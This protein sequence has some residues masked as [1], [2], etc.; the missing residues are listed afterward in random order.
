M[1]KRFIST[2]TAK[3]YP[4]PTT[5]TRDFVLIYG[6]EVDTT[7]KEQN[8]RHEV[9]YRTRKGWVPSDALGTNHPAELY[10][11]DV[12]Q[13]DATFIVTP[14]FRTI[15]V[16]G[17]RADEA[18]Q[19]LVWK[20][21]LDLPTATPVDL[22]LLVLSHTDDDHV[23]GLAQIVSHP[24]INVGRIVHSGIAKYSA[25]HF[26][27]DLGHVATFGGEKVLL[28]R[29]DGIQDLT[30]AQLTPELQAWFD[31]V[32]AK[33]SLLC[34]AVDST[35]PAFSLGDPSVEVH[36]LGPRLQ[37]TPR[38]PGYRWLGSASKTV[39]GHSVVLRVD[40]GS[41]RVLLPGDLNEAGAKYLMEEA[42]FT[43]NTG[44][45]I[46]KGPHHG[47]SDFHRL[48]LTAVRPQVSVVSSGESPDYGHPRANFLAAVGQAARS[49]EPL[50]FSTE[51]VAK[52]VPDADTTPLGKAEVVDPSDASLLTDAR[53]RFKKSLNGLINVRTDG[54]RIFA[55]RRVQ[56]G[57]QFETYGP[58]SVAP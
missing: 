46:L 1:A 43:T 56:A 34:N 4:G 41:T 16:D 21:R 37:S 2:A 51:L 12:G 53:Q 27:S 47:G 28:T 35:T 32:Q 33:Q 52:F 48:F 57:Y 45:H 14:Q 54:S 29:Y 42:T 26:N 3:F 5:S 15:L 31:A 38:G 23:A 17:G 22:D 39:N 44:G 9:F 19:F 50:L 6:D 20:Y 40:I 58:S 49:P 10:F 24:L 13:G 55:A 7:G 25:G 18:F 11:I 36:V 30:R 8:Q